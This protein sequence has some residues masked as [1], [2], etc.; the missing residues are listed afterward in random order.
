MPPENNTEQSSLGRFS[1]SAQDP[2]RDYDLEELSDRIDELEEILE[3]T[4]AEVDRTLGVV[5]E[6]LEDPDAATVAPER[7][8]VETAGECESEDE[9]NIGFQ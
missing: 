3:R 4:V 5:L 8:G 6:R 1:D 2:P 9:R 7:A